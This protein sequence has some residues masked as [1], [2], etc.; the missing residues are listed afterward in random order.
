MPSQHA[1]LSAAPLLPRPP[2]ETFERLEAQITELWGHLNAATY[3][4]LALVA[5]FDRHEGYA[6]HVLPSTAH[7]LNWQCGIGMIAAREKVRVARALESLPEIRAGFASGEFSYSKVRAMTRVA[8]PANEAVL[9]S[10]ARHGTASHVEKLVRKYRW[11]QQRDAQMTAQSQHLNRSVHWYFD[12]NETFVL[13]ARLPP[14]IGALVAQ[15]LQAAQ[16]VL[17]EQSSRDGRGEQRVRDERDELRP[18][19]DVNRFGWS[20]VSS[21]HTANRADALRLV[22]EAFLAMRSDEVEATSSADRCQIV[23]HVDQ[24]VLTKEIEARESEP[25]RAELDRGPA[26]ALETIRRLGCDGTL[27]GVLEG[28]D[29]EPLN[30]GRKSR[31]IPPAIKRA[32]RARDGGCR[33]PGCDRTRFCDGHHVKHWADG[34]ET[35]LGNL[36]TLCSFHHTLLHEGGFGVTATD[37]GVFVF[38]RPDGSRISDCG[39]AP[40]Q[41]ESRRFRGIVGADASSPEDA[42]FEARALDDAALDAFDA[43]IRYHGERLNA[44]SDA[45][46]NSSTARCKWLGERM[47]YS[48]AIESM[49]F[50]EEAARATTVA[51]S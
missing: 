15:A 26:L 8:T 42:S 46:I 2:P 39:T 43:A 3:R 22:A 33:F 29:G 44:G 25:H 35:K 16:D 4:F 12:A 20:S 6:R 49:Q 19:V 13:N 10:I 28:R 36:V 31:S 38:T 47:D 32:L 5:E 14:E 51:P 7:W 21:T 27:V 9:A 40:R 11:T 37:D 50:R 34:G 18:H 30:I 45:K 24:A 23:V 17:R 48:T 1:N 41:T